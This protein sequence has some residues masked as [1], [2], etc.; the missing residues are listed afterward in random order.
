MLSVSGAAP[1]CRQKPGTRASPLAC[2]PEACC[3]G[4]LA[5]RT[6]HTHAPFFIQYHTIACKRTSTSTCSKQPSTALRVSWQLSTPPAIK[7]CAW[8]TCNT[9]TLKVTALFLR[10]PNR[11]TVKPL[12][13][14]QAPNASQ[15]GCDA[16]PTQGLSSTQPIHSPPV[17]AEPCRAC[18][19]RQRLNGE[20]TVQTVSQ[21]PHDFCLGLGSPDFAPATP[22]DGWNCQGSCQVQDWC[23]G[24]S[25]PMRSRIKRTSTHTGSR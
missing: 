23:T 1:S 2:K 6:A 4:R 14:Q 25:L 18:A 12:R 5:I 9:S 8:G 11:Q 24:N 17:M 10:A 20:P 15:A 7:S 21:L 16:R 13:C 22:Q 19:Y 3:Q